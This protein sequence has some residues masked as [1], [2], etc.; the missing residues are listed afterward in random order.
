MEDAVKGVL[1]K[2]CISW[3]CF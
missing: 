1:L 2:I 3:L